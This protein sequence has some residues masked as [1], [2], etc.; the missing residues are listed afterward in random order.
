[1]PEICLYVQKAMEG[2]F[3]E[4]FAQGSPANQQPSGGGSHTLHESRDDEYVPI[5]QGI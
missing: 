1:M 3:D 2:A 5:Q 4:Y